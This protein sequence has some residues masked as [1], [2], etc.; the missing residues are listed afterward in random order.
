LAAELRDLQGQLGD[1]NT[2]VDKLNTD[3]DL[4]EFDKQFNQV[5]GKNAK[6]SRN[7]DE[8]FTKRKE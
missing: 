1:Y 3:T 5:K 8:M 2:V 4:E 6:T 7:L